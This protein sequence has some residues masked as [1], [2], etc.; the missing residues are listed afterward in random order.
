MSGL[1]IAGPILG[2]FPIALGAIQAY[3]EIFH[4]VK[5][6]DRDLRHLEHDLQTEELRIR[7]TYYTL[8]DGIVPCTEI[9]SVIKDPLGPQWNCYTEELHLRSYTSYD[10]LEKYVLEMSEAMKELRLRLGIEEGSQINLRDRKSILQVL[11]RHESFTLKKRVYDGILSRI[12]A[13]NAFLEGLA[14]VCRNLERDRRQKSQPRL[15]KFLRSQFR[16]AHNALCRV[17]TRTCTHSHSII[18]LQLVLRNDVILPIDV[19]EKIAQEL[20]FRIALEIG[21]EDKARRTVQPVYEARQNS[22]WEVF[23]LRLLLDDKRPPSPWPRSS[24]SAIPLSK[25]KFRWVSSINLA[26]IKRLNLSLLVTQ[27]VTRTRINPQTAAKSTQV[28]PP[29]VSNLCDIAQRGP[30]ATA[31]E[32]CGYI[33][34]ARRKFIFSHPNNDSGPQKHITLRQVINKSVPGLPPLSFKDKLQIALALSTGVLYLHG[35]PWLSQIVTLDDIVFMIGNEDAMNQRPAMFSRPFVIKRVPDTLLYATPPNILLTSTLPKP[36]TDAA[37]PNIE[38]AVLSLATLLIQIMLEHVDDRLRMPVTMD[39]GSLFSKYQR[40]SQLEEDIRVSGGINYATAVKWCLN[41][42]YSAAGLQNDTFCQ[43]FY[44]AVVAERSDKARIP[45]PSSPEGGEKFTCRH[46][47]QH[48]L[49]HNNATIM[50]QT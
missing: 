18:G 49:R 33:R 10:L 17:I 39:F 44:H 38:L 16:S 7:N 34:H 36:T 11:K 5:H 50:L 3:M 45:P 27:V 19:E 31:V 37:R 42:I 21:N 6:V 20:D 24:T 4:A 48:T 14:G 47:P 41:N 29:P 46:K 25:L 12:K 15:T 2:A 13:S 40:G 43:D 22:H 28:L 26:T 9:F 32:C 23:Q 8:L 30:E 1:E 35:T